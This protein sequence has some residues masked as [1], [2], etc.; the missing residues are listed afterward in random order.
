[1]KNTVAAVI[2]ILAGAVLLANNLGWTS[3]SL[4]RVIATWWP[5]LL[6]LAG[7]S[8]LLRHERR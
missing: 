6:I 5:V 2:L 3:I 4:G 1:M 8:L 7:L